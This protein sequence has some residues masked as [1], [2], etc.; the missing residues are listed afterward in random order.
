MVDKTKLTCPQCLQ[1]NAKDARHCELCDWPLKSV[2]D[3]TSLADLTT[4][5]AD[6][7]Q[8][9]APGADTIKKSS[10]ENHLRDK[11]DPDSTV[12]PQVLAQHKQSMN[13][14]KTFQ[15]AGD[16]S[17][18]E[19]YNGMWPSKCYALWRPPASSIPPHC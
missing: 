1:L 7:E 18:F 9:I 16:L 3:E 12:A 19:L 13:Q 6:S 2:A 11:Q 8:T 5:K 17:H 4:Q 14:S 15:L 10:S